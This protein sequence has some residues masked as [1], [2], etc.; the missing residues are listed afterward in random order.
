MQTIEL[1]RKDNYAILQLRRGKANVINQL[2]VDEIRAAVQEVQ[3]DDSIQGLIITGTDHFFSAGLDV[4]EL[5]GYD[6][7]AIRNFFIAFGQ[8]HEELTR[9]PK[10][11]ICAISGHAPAG[12]TVIAITADY[13]IM[14][15]G[16][17]YSMGLNEMAV[18]IQISQSL[19]DAYAFWIGHSKANEFLLDGRLLKPQEAL[20]CGLVNEVVEAENL[21]ARAEE[22]MQQYLMADPE[23][24]QNTKAKLRKYWL[25]EMGANS[26]ADL[27]EAMKIW[28][29]PSIRERMKL[30]VEMLT[31]KKK[32]RA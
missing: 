1:K 23:I 31:S 3:K 14:A 27:E 24:F 8:L 10:A 28:W 21:M 6:K 9:F 15:E 13:R 7:V 22:K 18:N 20:A 11:L 26:Q 19:V 29:K 16:E 12:G 32:D 2:M 17:K 30:F 4:I 25:A 5:Y